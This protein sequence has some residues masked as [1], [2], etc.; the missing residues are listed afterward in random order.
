M[1]LSSLLVGS[2]EA[3]KVEASRLRRNVAIPLDLTSQEGGYTLD[4]SMM[5]TIKQLP[6]HLQ[7]VVTLIAIMVSQGKE[8]RLQEKRGLDV[9]SQ[10]T[11]MILVVSVIFLR[12][13][14]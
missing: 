7:L 12:K 6:S 13:F 14:S 9:L 8:D 3:A 11:S 10:A 5:S 1:D 2:S 4:P